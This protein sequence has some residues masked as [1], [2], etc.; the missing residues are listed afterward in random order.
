MRQGVGRVG[1]DHPPEDQ[2]VQGE[3]GRVRDLQLREPANMVVRALQIRAGGAAPPQEV[4]GFVLYPC[5]QIV[6]RWRIVAER[7]GTLQPVL[8]VGGNPL[9]ARGSLHRPLVVLLVVGQQA[10]RRGRGL[11]VGE[12]L[13]A[14]RKADGGAATDR[15]CGRHHAGSWQLRAGHA[16]AEPR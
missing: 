15:D 2:A 5:E 12:F 1:G 13:V 14:S 7:G 6:Q 8:R 4:V 11:I 16:L 10:H 3:A 9:S